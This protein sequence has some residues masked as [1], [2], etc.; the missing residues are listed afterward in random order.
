[1][2]TETLDVACF[3]KVPTYGDFVRHRATGA[4]WQ[5]IDEWV[6]RGLYKAKTQLRRDLDTAYDAAGTSYFLFSAADVPQVLVGA[7]QPSRDQT[8]RKYPFLVGVELDKTSFDTDYITLPVRGQ[9]FLKHAS[10]LV[11]DATDGRIGHRDLGGRLDRIRTSGAAT[12]VYERYLRE[13]TFKA[14]VEDLWG[15]FEGTPKY[16]LFKNLTEILLPFAGNSHLGL[17]LGL[18]FPLG[19]DPDVAAHHAGFWLELCVRMLETPTVVP[20]F[21]WTTSN[22]SA[23]QR[24]SLL[25]Y[26]QTPTPDAFVHLL[27]VE[28]DSDN[29]CELDRAG[30]ESAAQVALSIPSKYGALLESDQ[31]NLWE[32][33]RKL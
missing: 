21:F 1:M 11:E 8:G 23:E 20:S 15:H 31:L 16:L 14:F 7:M 4:A 17:S 29:I 18:K 27:P 3:G 10:A 30:E 33:L 25:L 24:P 19:S 5:A 9:P 13:T 22:G 6:Q 2:Q 28:F 32:F 12:R 26:F